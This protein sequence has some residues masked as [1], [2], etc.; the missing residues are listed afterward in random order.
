MWERFNH[1]SDKK[2]GTKLETRLRRK[3]GQ[4]FPAQLLLAA[5][6]NSKGLII[7]FAGSAIDITERKSREEAIYKASL[8]NRS[9]IEASLDP[10]V[11]IGPDGKIT[12]VNASTETATGFNRNEL[13]GTDFSD[14]FTEPDKARRG[15]QQVFREGSVRDYPLELKHRDGHAIPVLYNATVFHDEQGNLIGVFAAAR[16]ITE[17]KQTEQT[18]NQ[19]FVELATLYASGLAL[20]HLMSA[21]EIGQ[22]LIGIMGSN[23]NWHHTTI[24]LYNPEDESLELLAFNQPDTRSTAQFQAVE[25]RFKSMI[26]KAGDG[27]SGWA[28]KH[29]QVVRVG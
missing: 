12:D 16:D 13:I 7:G 15:Y 4:E 3:S 2:A 29:Q 24:R 8:Y 28:V 25:Q 23:M 6:K 9:L 21:K 26:S 10:L 20:S 14:Y 17:R 11:T 5:L 19:R 1:R 27:L 22:K 18:I